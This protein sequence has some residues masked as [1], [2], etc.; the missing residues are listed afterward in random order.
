MSQSTARRGIT[1]VEILVSIAILGVLIALLLPAIQS[2][3]DSA[4]KLQCQNNLRQ[5]SI[6]TQSLHA[7]EEELPSLYNGTSLQYPLREWDLFHMHSWRVPLLPYL[8]H[9]DLGSRIAWD[10]LATS[11]GNLPVAQEVVPS[12]I[13]P[14]GGDPQNM[15]RG[16]KHEHVGLSI[17]DIREEHLYGVT[18]SDYD[19]M[20][21][22]QILPEPYPEGT[23]PGSVE[24]VRWGVWGW[25]IF[26]GETTA[27]SRLLRYRRGKFRDIKDGLSHT[28]A[29]V[30]RAGKPV[31]L[32]NGQPNVTPDNP[33][34]AYPG[35]SGWSASNTFAW[36]INNADVGVNQS[37]SV[38]IY[39]FHSGGAN[40]ALA[41]GSVRMLSDSTDFETLVKLYGRSNG[42]SLE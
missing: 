35:Q 8:E 6:A 33:D 16:L 23:D 2:A 28:I 36:S 26:D 30:E 24:F 19:A 1:L 14:S 9:A 31:D 32:L 38:G 10:E 39:S 15:G 22:I 3:R 17:S 7:A 20:A 12:F 13:C 34:A 37:N 11:P 18:R 42:R 29:I 4:R 41:D 25:P 5:I 40:V 21:G 27:G